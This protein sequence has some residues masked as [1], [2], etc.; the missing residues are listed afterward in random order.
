MELKRDNRSFRTAGF[1]AASAALLLI[2]TEQSS[3]PPE[4]SFSHEPSRLPARRIYNNIPGHNIHLVLEREGNFL[5]RG[6][7][8]THATLD[9]AFASAKEK[10]KDE[11]REVFI[12]D[13]RGRPFKED[14]RGRAGRLTPSRLKSEVDKRGGTYLLTTAFQRDLPFRALKYLERGDVVIH[15]NEGKDRTGF[16]FGRLIESGISFSNTEGM[17]PVDIE[18]GKRYQ[19]GIELPM[20][21]FDWKEYG[22]GA[23]RLGY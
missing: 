19:R 7:A 17:D 15:C 2:A 8:P 4:F 21:E 12:I 5:I 10:K 11:G 6:G 13:L 16:F 1:R 14:L 9:A 22:K 18:Q 20:L 3:F 23:F